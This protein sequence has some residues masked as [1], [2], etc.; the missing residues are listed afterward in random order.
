M[1]RDARWLRKGVNYNQWSH[2]HDSTHNS[3]LNNLS[4]NKKMKVKEV[5]LNQGAK[6]KKMKIPTEMRMKN[7]SQ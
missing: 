1:L 5:D 2:P 4:L 3:L 6:E 7:L